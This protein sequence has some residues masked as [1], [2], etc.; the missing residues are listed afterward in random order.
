MRIVTLLVLLG[1]MPAAGQ[2]LI[3]TDLALLEFFRHNTVPGVYEL[4][5]RRYAK[6]G[7]AT[8]GADE[9][10]LS[11]TAEQPVVIRGQ[12]I[13]RT[14]IECPRICFFSGNSHVIFEDL[15][16]HGAI[17]SAHL[18][19]W[20]FR[21][22]KF[23][24]A[25]TP[26]TS[27]Q[28][29][30]GQ[31]GGILFK[32]AGGGKGAGPLRFERVIFDPAPIPNPDTT[33]DF[34]GV[35]GV[36]IIDSVF[37]RCNRGCMQAKGGSGAV[38]PYRWEGNL[39][40][41]AG[42]RGIFFGGGAGRRFFD[43]PID[44]SRHEFGSAV[45]R[46][47]VIIGGLACFAGSTFGGPVL[48]ENN[49]CIGQSRFYWR[50]LRENDDAE[51]AQTRDLT[52][53]R[54]IFVGFTGENELAFNYS[55]NAPSQGHF[56]WD[57]FL[58]EENAFDRDPEMGRYWPEGVVTLNNALGVDAGILMDSGV[59]RAGSPEL[60]AAGIGPTIWVGPARL[61]ARGVVSAA[62]FRGGSVAPDEI[63]SIFGGGFGSGLH[64]ATAM[65][66]PSELGGVAA[67]LLDAFGFQQQLRM[68]VVSPRQIN[69]ILPPNLPLGE[70]TLQ[71]TVPGDP[72]VSEKVRVERVAP[73]I[74]SANATG[75]GMAA[76]ATVR[77]AP[78][79]V[80]MP[81]QALQGAG[82]LSGFPIDLGPDDEQVVLLLF[83]TGIRNY[84]SIRVTIGGVE[85]EVVGVL[86][87]P[88]FAGLDQINAVIPRSLAGRGEVEVL[89]A[90]DGVE[91][92]VVT[93]VVG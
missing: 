76:A 51:I 33:L 22:V 38:I 53:R 79:G 74:F 86:H 23:S 19:H 78:G 2:A 6:P 32:T 83:G 45:I 49:L 87:Q 80:P 73:G 39:I 68:L 72:T 85:A 37:E 1:A 56:V 47:N 90:I 7:S 55:R 31:A 75:T 71:V 43:P 62:S 44:I 36:E 20:T 30:G 10:K 66:L 41:D 26:G 69:A 81:A 64:V 3:E 9:G 14:I 52:I 58:I 24:D 5:A 25:V 35:Q 50:A 63:I 15:T 84:S 48:V 88:E 29:F 67:V 27:R 82:P 57:S 16:I 28:T 92:N 54:N 46:N 11:G 12:G 59:P 89:V 91:A 60:L 70:S 4:S 18:K 40:K 61:T 93:I 8:F 13:D 17:N 34:V 21:R 65:P 42:D 77:I